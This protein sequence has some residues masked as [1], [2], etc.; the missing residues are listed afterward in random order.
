MGGGQRPLRGVLSFEPM[1]R[2]MLN[3]TDS[4]SNGS[5]LWNFTPC[6]SLNSQVVGLR[7]PHE[8]AGGAP[9]R[10][11]AREGPGPKHTRPFE[12]LATC[13]HAS[14]LLGAPDVS[15]SP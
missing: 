5:P 15:R 6:R 14:L 10:P 2:S 9:P 8:G 11:A 13:Q 1:M 3:F 7:F 4:P 12:R